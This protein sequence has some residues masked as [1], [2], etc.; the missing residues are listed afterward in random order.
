MEKTIE[1]LIAELQDTEDL[2]FILFKSD[3][4]DDKCMG[5]VIGTTD[6]VESISALLEESAEEMEAPDEEDVIH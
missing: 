4:D 6:F 5:M 3:T 1:E 2:N